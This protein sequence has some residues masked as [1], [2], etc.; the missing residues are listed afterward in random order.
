MVNN[1]GQDITLFDAFGEFFISVKDG[2]EI[3]VRSKKQVAYGKFLLPRVKINK[4]GR[5]VKVMDKEKEVKKRLLKYPATYMALSILRDY[6]SPSTNLI[7]KNGMKYRCNM[8]AEEMG[9][10]RQMASI[11]FKRLQEYNLIAEVETP[12]GMYW[13]INPTYYCC[14][15]EI[16][17]KVVDAFDKKNKNS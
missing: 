5:F 9:I 15:D 10:T 6:I 16:P 7:M 3:S 2:E 14:S 1:T 8:L 11:H 4:K 13:A 12:R 17:Q